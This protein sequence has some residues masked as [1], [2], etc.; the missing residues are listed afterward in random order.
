MNI[1]AYNNAMKELNG[2]NDIKGY[3]G[4]FDL[5]KDK[6][7]KFKLMF[8]LPNGKCLFMPYSPNDDGKRIGEYEHMVYLVKAIELILQEF[9]IDKKTFIEEKL[10]YSDL[11]DLFYELINNILKLNISFFCDL[12]EID[13]DSNNVRLAWFYKSP[14]ITEK[15]ENT[16]VK[17]RNPLVNENYGLGI[18]TLVSDRNLNIKMEDIIIII[19]GTK[20]KLKEI[21][22]RETDY[23]N[24]DDFYKIINVDLEQTR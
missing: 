14:N 22:G 5:E 13:S 20:I 8:I 2:A 4:S 11:S 23:L 21:L 6:I 18:Q 7:S 24:I 1:E 10:N 9:G 19:N 17:L 3:W 12:N 16:L 15:Q